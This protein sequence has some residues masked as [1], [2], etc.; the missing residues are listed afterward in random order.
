MLSND[1]R[2]TPRPSSPDP[3]I[4][5]P[6]AAPM[7]APIGPAKPPYLLRPDEQLIE[8]PNSPVRKCPVGGRFRGYDLVHVSGPCRFCSGQ[9]MGDS[10]MTVGVKRIATASIALVSASAIAIAPT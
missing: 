6:S 4:L 5:L 3:P 8:A 7:V 2:Q 9:R 1:E 10:I